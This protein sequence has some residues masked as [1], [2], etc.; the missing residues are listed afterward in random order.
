MHF[1]G[2]A[3]LR[4]GERELV[5]Q[6]LE[7]ALELRERRGHGRVEETRRALEGMTG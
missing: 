6:R 1:C 7:A 2:V 5:F 3:R 4:L